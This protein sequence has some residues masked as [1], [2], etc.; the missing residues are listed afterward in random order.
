ME[1]VTRFFADPARPP[2]I[3]WTVNL[4]PFQLQRVEDFLAGMGIEA[5]HTP[6]DYERILE[7]TLDQRQRW[8]TWTEKNG[9]RE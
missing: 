8:I 1:K 4:S 5:I 6:F 2:T 7:M 3:R 9:I